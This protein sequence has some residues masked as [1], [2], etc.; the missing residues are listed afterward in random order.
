[1]IHL[2]MCVLVDALTASYSRPAI[3]PWRM[4]DS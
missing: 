2:D 4:M 1:M 3:P